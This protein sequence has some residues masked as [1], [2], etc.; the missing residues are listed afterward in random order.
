M[1]TSVEA[2]KAIRILVTWE[3]RNSSPRGALRL[4][5]KGRV[6]VRIRGIEIMCA[7]VKMFVNL[8]SQ[9]SR[10]CSPTLIFDQVP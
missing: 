10:V 8:F 6:E 4:S 1:G 5:E 7:E 2:L 3:N 9:T